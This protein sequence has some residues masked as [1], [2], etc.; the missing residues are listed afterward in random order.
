MPM[1]VEMLLISGASL[2]GAQR[3]QDG[4]G[5]PAGRGRVGNAGHQN[6]E[7]VAAEARHHLAL[8]RAP[9]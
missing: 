4:L 3:F 7:L 6:G 9:R 1:L 5:E 8:A 2:V